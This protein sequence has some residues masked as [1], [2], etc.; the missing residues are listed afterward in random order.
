[1]LRIWLLVLRKYFL[2]IKQQKIMSSSLIKKKITRRLIRNHKK[3][4]PCLIKKT[5][6]F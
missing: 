2:I 4:F 5:N 3:T 1:M 6:V